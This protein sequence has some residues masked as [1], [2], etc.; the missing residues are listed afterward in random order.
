MDKID[1]SDVELSD[2]DST[3]NYWYELIKPE[4]AAGGIDVTPRA[5]EAWRS[6]GGGPEFVRISSRCVRYRRIDI[7]KWANGLLRKSTSDDG[8]ANAT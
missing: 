6:R 4:V 7:K 1:C 2:P 3:E 8:Q 5:L